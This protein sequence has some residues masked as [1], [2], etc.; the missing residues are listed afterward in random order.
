MDLVQR[1]PGSF[2]KELQAHYFQKSGTPKKKT[3]W[4]HAKILTLEK[5]HLLNQ[6]LLSAV[7]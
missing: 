6:I 3:T 5:L 2:E 1:L 7:C 4:Y